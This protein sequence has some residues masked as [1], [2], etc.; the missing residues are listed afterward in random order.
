[1]IT[2]T[3]V[4]KRCHNNSSNNLV[5]LGNKAK[6]ESKHLPSKRRRQCKYVEIEK[7]IVQ[8]NFVKSM[9]LVNI[10]YDKMIT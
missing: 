7:A 5:M 9:L 3:M 4:G 1:M 6:L 2:A 10:F 8:V